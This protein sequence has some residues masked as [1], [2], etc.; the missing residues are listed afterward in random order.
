MKMPVKMLS[1]KYPILPGLVLHGVVAFMNYLISL[2]FLLGSSGLLDLR[3][4]GPNR[5]ASPLC[6][7]AIQARSLSP[8]AMSVSEI[9]AAEI[10]HEVAFSPGSCPVCQIF[11][12]EFT[13]FSYF[14]Q[15]LHNDVVAIY[16]LVFVSCAV[17]ETADSQACSSSSSHQSSRSRTHL[18]PATPSQASILSHI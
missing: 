6:V 11:I 5:L 10:L 14:A 12:F 4:K 3:L 1:L 17:P 15:S 7:S 2:I 18:T 16:H 8:Q 9:R 13:S